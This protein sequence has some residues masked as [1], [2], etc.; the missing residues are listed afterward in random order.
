MDVDS[1]KRLLVLLFTTPLLYVGHKLGLSDSLLLTVV[2]LFATYIAQ[3][4]AKAIAA[5]LGKNKG[6]ANAFTELQKLAG[7]FDQAKAM[8][9]ANAGSAA[10][11][12]PGSPSQA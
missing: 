12:K 1:L 2:G 5:E 11:A 4:G 6:L 7:A 9:A 10:A 3:S 8:A